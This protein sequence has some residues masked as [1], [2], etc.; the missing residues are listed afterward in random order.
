MRKLSCASILTL[1]LLTPAVAARQACDVELVEL[2]QLTSDAEF[3]GFP[4]LSFSPASPLGHLVW[5]KEF[6]TGCDR[7][8]DLYVS[9]YDGRLWSPATFLAGQAPLSRHAGF[10]LDFAPD[11]GEELLVFES[12]LAQ[13]LC[14]DE[15]SAQTWSGSWQPGT[16]AIGDG[17]DD[18]DVMGTVRFAEDGTYA[19]LVW[20]D[21]LDFTNEDYA[22]A[23]NIY[24]P[25]LGSFGPKTIIEPATGTNTMRPRHDRTLAQRPGTGEWIL[26]YERAGEVYFQSGLGDVNGLVWS[27]EQLLSSSVDPDYRPLIRFAQDGTGYAFW[28]QRTNGADGE[29]MAAAYDEQTLSFGPPIAL[30]SNPQEEE[31]FAVVP[32]AGGWHVIFTRFPPGESD[33]EVFWGRFDGISLVDEERLT[34][35]D[36][37]QRQVHATADD[38]GRLHVTYQ[39]DGEVWVGRIVESNFPAMERPRYAT[40]P[41]AL[42]LNPGLTSGPILGQ[43][44]DPWLSPFPGSVVDVLF[45]DLGGPIETPTPWGT[46]LCNV[47]APFRIF[48]LAPG[49]VFSVG[50][51][52]SCSLIGRTACSQGAVF[53][54]PGFEL[55]NA[56]D[57][58]FGTY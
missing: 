40:P 46:L 52:N 26:V 14:F 3:D 50:I 28:M 41:N 57:L 1:S 2:V 56:L 39:A 58:V 29:L 30:T 17:V 21:D 4:V 8:H 23:A 16:T 12:S 38:F 44:W 11:G 36:L 55:S 22:I 53:L 35:D 20:C 37:D 25:I 19:L 9:E 27:G 15:I 33:R 51:P 24:D 32:N 49:G 18:D 31:L 43:V 5:S 34:D 54:A 48:K 7:S 13:N 10:S 45:V 6:G 47:P 42:T